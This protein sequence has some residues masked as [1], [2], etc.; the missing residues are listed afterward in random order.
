MKTHNI[1]LSKAHYDEAL[2]VLNEHLESIK[3][4]GD[5]ILE[6]EDHTRILVIFRMNTYLFQYLDSL[7]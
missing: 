1:N 4:T 6:L 2:S 3:K 7:I 5:T